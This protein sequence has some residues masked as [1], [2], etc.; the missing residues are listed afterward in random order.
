[1]QNNT[2]HKAFIW[3]MTFLHKLNKTPPTKNLVFYIS[4]IQFFLMPLVTFFL[5]INL[6]I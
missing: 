2:A 4:T 6:I 5:A 3:Q 1:M